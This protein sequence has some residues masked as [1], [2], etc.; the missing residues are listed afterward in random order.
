MGGKPAREIVSQ[1][2]ITDVWIERGGKEG[3]GGG[4]YY[5]C[6]IHSIAIYSLLGSTFVCEYTY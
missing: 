2:T 4:L 3:S 1:L 6:V 5:S